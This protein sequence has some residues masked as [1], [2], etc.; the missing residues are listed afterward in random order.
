MAT[1]SSLLFTC[2]IENRPARPCAA[3]GADA[4]LA[5][6]EPVFKVAVGRREHAAIAP[7]IGSSLRSILRAK[8]AMQC[9]EHAGGTV[10]HDGVIERLAFAAG[11]DDPVLAEQ[12]KLL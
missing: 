4:H 9:F 12:S 6:E 2:G 11:G 8:D 3:G 1:S 7:G 5:A 10:V